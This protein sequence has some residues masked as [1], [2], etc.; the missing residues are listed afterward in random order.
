M[1]RH[2]TVAAAPVRTASEA[3]SVVST[4]LRD[5]LE[6]SPAI[7]PG[8]VAEALD[9]LNPIAPALIAGGYLEKQGLVLVD[10]G[11]HVTVTVVTADAALRIEENLTPVPGGATATDGWTLHIVTTGPLAEAVRIATS[12]RPHLSTDPP[13]TRRSAKESENETQASVVD[14]DALRQM[15]GPR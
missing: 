9:P 14:L 15:R 7:P 1:E 10:E 3:W 4:L 11:L 2:R 12:K 8:S 13:P 6:R 5:T